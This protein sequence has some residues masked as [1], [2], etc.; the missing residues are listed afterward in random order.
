MDEVEVFNRGLTPTEVAS[1]Y[2]AGSH[3]K[4]PCT[5]A[6]AGLISWW[7]A[8][9]DTV[10]T[11]DGNDGTFNGTSAY[12]S[13]EVGRA[14][15]FNNDA[16]S[17]VLIP[18][19]TNLD[20]AAF[21]VD[22]WVYPTGDSTNG[23]GSVVDKEASTGGIN[24]AL[25]VS[26]DG[27]VEIDFN[28]GAHQFVDSPP[29]AAPRN[30]WTHIVGTY[31][32]P[33]GSKELKLYVN[34][35]LIGTH[36]AD[37]GFETPPTGQ[38]LFIGVRNASTLA[39]PFN[40]LIDEVEVFSRALSDT[41]VAA[42]Y[43]AG[44]AG[45]CRSCT[46]APG[47]MISW[48][49]AEANA[50]DNADSNNG[51]F[52]GTPAYSAGEVGQAF[53][54]DGNSY[55]RI[56]DNTNLHFSN[57]FTLDAWVYPTDLSGAPII[58]SKFGASNF[59]YELHLYSG[60]AVRSNISGDGTTYD[61]LISDPGVVSTNSW[62][63]V[64]TT[65]NAGDWRIYVNGV[66]VASKSSTVTSIYTGTSD[67]LI[68]S[69]TSNFFK[70]LIDEAEVFGRA[71]TGSEVRKIYDAGSKGKCPCTPPP[72]GL[73]SWWPADLNP[74]DYQDNNHGMLV[75]GATYANGE[76][77]DA[78]S[79]D[80]TSGHVSVP[81][82]ANQSILAAISIDAWVMKKGNCTNNC[83]VL[84]KQTD[85]N[86]CCDMLRYGLIVIEPTHAVDF[87]FNTGSWQDVVYSNTTIQ[88]N[89]WYHIAGT[90]DG[91]TAKIYVNGVLDNS[92]SK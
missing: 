68:G 65:F 88:D 67:L 10:D 56:P 3:V 53:S 8:E 61:S 72:S 70:G 51:T 12:G 71:L 16:S 1:L 36:T 40:G 38:D 50:N 62:A 33:N 37:P 9:D 76:V 66:E 20:L 77:G 28:P 54:F 43:T 32:G 18:H 26:N 31:D 84:M 60:G 79:F 15:S 7:K 90:Y 80:G 83:I 47:G 23:Y 22:A 92:V 42:I 24:Y 29:G 48:W 21:T 69:D 30:T 44:G 82:N 46:K 34:G 57:Q 64:T 35:V 17:Y 75:G 45:K 91:A 14:F 6:P 52:N 55:V 4:C 81:H 85:D 5:P 87:A 11:A 59:S 74:F 2:I 19:N 25:F 27:T 39:A 63:H 13:G 73:V 78:F 41:E 58:F 49:K 89:V 86:A